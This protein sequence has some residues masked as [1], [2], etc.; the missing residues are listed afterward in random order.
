MSKYHGIATKYR[1]Y[2]F[3]SRHEAK[4]A[5]FFDLCGW[6]WSY[7]PV[8]LNGWIPDFRV[9]EKRTL[10]EIKPFTQFA[11]WKEE[12]VKIIRSGCSEDVLLLGEDPT[13]VNDDVQPSAPQFGYVLE[14]H[15]AL[16]DDDK[17]FIVPQVA[18]LHFGITEGNGKLGLCPMDAG[19][20]N[21]IWRAP[22]TAYANKWSR[23]SLARDEIEE[24][25]VEKWAEACNIAKWI[26][27]E[28]KMTFITKPIDLSVLN[29]QSSQMQ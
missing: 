18:N 27:V 23:V 9:G 22:D 3:R 4:Y 20:V 28:Q 15:K 11:Q 12:I 24:H 1:N 25:L 21:K 6:R 29:A 8:D 13:W 2:E 14:F 5:V 19:W 7:E 26:P 10:V 17:E 16:D